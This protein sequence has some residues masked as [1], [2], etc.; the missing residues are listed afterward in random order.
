[1]KYIITII[2]CLICFNSYSLVN[3]SIFLYHK[4]EGLPNLSKSINNNQ[5]IKI[6][7]LGGSITEQNGW[8]VLNFDFFKKKYNRNSFKEIN[9]SMG[10]TGSLLGGLRL[11]KDVL[12]YNP[13]LVF[14]EFAVNDKSMPDTLVIRS[15]EGIVRKIWKNN[16]HCDICF[17]Y[18][19][20]AD[21]I[22]EIGVNKIHHTVVSMEKVAE[23]YG[24]PTVY[25]PYYAIQLLKQGKLKMKCGSDI[26][27]VVSGNKLNISSDILKNNDTI[28]FSKDG[29]HPFLNTGHI[30][31]DKALSE[32]LINL[33]TEDDKSYLHNLI[34][35]KDDKCYQ[36]T[37][38]LLLSDINKSGAW[39]L[40]DSNFNLFPRY[41]KR[42]DELWVGEINST[43]EFSFKGRSL[44]AYDL[45]SPEGCKLD[46]TVDGKNF[47]V[48]RF[49][50][51]STYFRF[52]S[53]TL[54]SDLDPL[55]EH[56]I[57]IKITDNGLNKQKILSERDPKDIEMNPNKY[58]PVRWYVNSIF[59][60]K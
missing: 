9:A 38:Q 52:H 32:S 24:I 10:G 28:Y 54:V 14:I 13:D 53:A 2:C 48:N 57:K 34:Q 33:I 20:T 22:D 59:V 25:L 18:T 49:D 42:F 6:A 23:Y 55:V 4:R 37:D 58:K 50:K 15:M 17:V 41:K 44:V 26:A 43:L 12:N 5:E 7:Y 27:N 60:I 31:Y 35:P 11:K 40:I 8:R 39:K 51:Y 56:H 1:M 36:K 29:V 45:I 21:I 30:L 46:I 19:T 47:S 16:P 3:D